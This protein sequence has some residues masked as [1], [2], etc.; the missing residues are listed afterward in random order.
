MKKSGA[1]VY[2]MPLYILYTHAYIF[3]FKTAGAK[4]KKNIARNKTKM[5]NSKE[6]EKYHMV[7]WIKHKYKQ[8]RECIKIFNDANKTK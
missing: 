5:K 6:I 1:L 3:A 2:T 4:Y 7:V 8:G